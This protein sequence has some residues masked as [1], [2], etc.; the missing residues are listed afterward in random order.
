MSSTEPMA[1]ESDARERRRKKILASKNERMSKIMSSISAAGENDFQGEKRVSQEHEKLEKAI[2][3]EKRSL[4]Q[5][6]KVLKGK[7]DAS[8]DISKS[9]ASPVPT[10][11]SKKSPVITCSHR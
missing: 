5:S 11:V 4:Q 3:A 1:A 6:N 10:G 2:E 8:S 7:P 9:S